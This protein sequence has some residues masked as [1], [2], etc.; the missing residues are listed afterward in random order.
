MATHTIEPERA[1]LHGHF[2][3][4]LPPVLTVDPGDTVRFRTLD[5]GWT[6]ET[7]ASADAERK[8]FE[9]REK[10][11]DGGHCLC[12]PVEVRGAEPGGVLE[13]KINEIEVGDWGWGGGWDGERSAQLG[14]QKG[15]KCDLFWTLDAAAGIATS[16]FGHTVSLRPF[17]GVMG[18]PP[19]EPGV[20][21]TGPPRNSGG[22]L[23]CKELVAGT[24]LY[25]PISVR[26]GLFSTGDGH[27]VQ[28]DGEVSGVAIECP[29]RKVDLTFDLCDD[30]RLTTPRARVQGGWITMGLHED[31]D[32]ATLLA[33]NSMVDLMVEQFGMTRV[34]SV[35]LASLVVDMRITQIVN[36]TCGVHAFLPDGA[37]NDDR[38]ETE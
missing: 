24:T 5:A 18:M 4:D 22:N 37:L 8:R 25:L 9:P 1:T 28:G 6:V 13:V 2:S 34:E 30:L 11:K 32:E 29:M 20:H 36:G 26:G 21:S 23:D 16:Q 38:S 3:P 7:P 17:M 33:L 19:A 15:E 31:L 35:A 12:G 10:G 14:V 27:G